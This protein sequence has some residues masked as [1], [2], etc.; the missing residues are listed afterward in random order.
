LK[1]LIRTNKTVLK[2]LL[3]ISLFSSFCLLGFA[4]W[5]TDRILTIGRN[6]LYFED[7]V[8]SIQYFNQVI[9][10]KPYLAEPYMYRAMAK[11]QLGDDKGAELD[12]AEAIERNPFMP[13]AY[14]I[15]GFARRRL[16]LF[17]DAVTDFSKAIEFS[18]NSLNLL[19]NRMDALV[20]LE[21]YEGAMR[22]LESYIRQ[23]PKNASLYYEKGIIQ[24]SMKDTVG[25]QNSFEELL[26][27]DS[28]NTLGWSALGLLKMQKKDIQGAYNDYSKAIQHKSAFYGDFINRGII[29]VQLKNFREALSDYDQAI[30][31]E[32]NSDLAYYNRALLRANLGDNNNA[33]ADLNKV[34]ELDTTHYEALLQRAMMHNNLRQYKKA[35]ADY[36]KIIKQYPYF[37]PAYWGISEAEAG[38]GNQKNAFKYRQMAS[39]IEKNKDKIQKQ[40]KDEIIAGNK[41]AS[42]A[43]KSSNS[44]KTELFNRFATQDIDDSKSDSKYAD[45]RRGNVQDKYADVLN[46]RNFV[47]SYYAKNDEIRR[48]NLYHS[49]VDDYNKKRLLGTNL[50]ITN[51]E[52]PLTSELVNT[53]FEIINYVSSRLNNDAGNA[54]L[55]FY[56]AV[57]FALVQ[58]F[59]SSVE[60]LNRALA[61][62]P[63]FA[64]A[65]FSRANI[66]YKL[67]DYVRNTS[68][69]QA[70][71]LNESRSDRT[72]KII[73]EN[74]YKFDVELIMRDLDKVIELQP[75]FAYAYYNKANILCTQ[76]DFKTAINN[77]SKAVA[78][79]PDF[80]EAYFNRGLTYLFTGQDEKGLADLSK[81][82]ELGIYQSYN[83]I[84]RF[85]N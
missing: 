52:I 64:L 21:D 8:L 2:K 42:T 28:T 51:N 9:K 73:M 31:L 12:A 65:Y 67:V 75:D 47:L 19:M 43:P 70:S 61:I 4:Q 80:A 27:Q 20:R 55:F 34:L 78:I 29:N 33:L 25:A 6:A 66:R 81:A 84:Q 50:K 83:L 32:K 23:T 22:D 63:D 49:L 13:Q 68:N 58:D 15:R 85:G 77:Y 16:G 37:I 54:D 57:E 46:E 53:H 39:D 79:D 35:I 36:N 5:N 72:N 71:T 82:G 41:M 3:I 38:L 45:S 60:D 14:Y 69:E 18:P 30:K 62:R 48:T 56:R 1:I 59:N 44:K 24:L 76:Q 17:S 26:K 74:Q 7:Y 40:K 11:I 10:I